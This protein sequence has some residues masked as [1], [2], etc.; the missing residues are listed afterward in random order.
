MSTVTIQDQWKDEARDRAH[1]VGRV[2]AYAAEKV[3]AKDFELKTIRK[4]TATLNVPTGGSA[5]RCGGA[6]V[7]SPGSVNNYVV[8]S[9]YNIHNAGSPITYTDTVEELGSATRGS[10]EFDAVGE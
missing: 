3:Y 5:V 4:F 9:H 10:F 7:G 1:V 8:F 2:A 6:Y